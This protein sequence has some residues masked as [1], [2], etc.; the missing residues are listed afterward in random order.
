MSFGSGSRDLGGPGGRSRTTSA[1]ARGRRGRG[2]DGDGERGGEANGR[3]IEKGWNDRET[4]T[5]DKKEGCLYLNPTNDDSVEPL[6]L[7]KRSTGR[8]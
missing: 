1:N 6:S 2:R 4:E 8:C 5:K 7:S 3:E